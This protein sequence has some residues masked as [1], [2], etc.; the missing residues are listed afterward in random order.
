MGVEGA[1]RRGDLD[2]AN[3]FLSKIT[4]VNDLGVICGYAIMYQ[5][6]K[7]GHSQL[8]ELLPR[9]WHNTLHFDYPTGNCGLK[10]AAFSGDTNHQG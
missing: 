3:F 7:G 1:C 2:L 8:V 9:K 6:A 5:A 10:A 4:V